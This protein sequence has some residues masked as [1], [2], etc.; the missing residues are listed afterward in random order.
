[1]LTLS[2][3]SPGRSS[4]H[5]EGHIWPCGKLHL[6]SFLHNQLTDIPLFY[7]QY[8]NLTCD[9]DFKHWMG[10]TSF[11]LG[12]PFRLPCT[13]RKL[14]LHSHAWHKH[15]FY[16]PPSRFNSW[17]TRRDIY[18]LLVVLP[19]T[20]SLRFMLYLSTCYKE[21]TVFWVEVKT[22]LRLILRP[23]YAGLPL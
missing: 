9:A 10:T 19:V 6:I 1:M 7:R 4:H 15:L 12:T 2:F 18:W 21:G 14:Y 8:L 17:Y 11:R 20:I 23:F 5:R 13:Q 22:V 3:P 16:H